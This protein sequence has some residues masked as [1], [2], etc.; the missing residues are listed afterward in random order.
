VRAF[1]DGLLAALRNQHVDLL[2]EI[3]NSRDLGDATGAKLKSVVETFA[4][5]FA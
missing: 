1:E 4:K 3:R 5:T 2:T